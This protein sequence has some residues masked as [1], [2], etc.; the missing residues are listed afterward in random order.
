MP[1]FFQA[2]VFEVLGEKV[3]KKLQFERINKEGKNR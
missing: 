2:H 1:N 3:T